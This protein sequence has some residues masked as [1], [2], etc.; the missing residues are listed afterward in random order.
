MLELPAEVPMFADRTDAGRR[1]ATA[2]ISYRGQP[3]VVFALPRGGVVLGVE[4]SRALEA[5]LDLIVVRKIGHPQSPEY[6]VGA[7]TEDGDIVL[8][9]DEAGLL[10]RDWITRTAE[11]ELREAHRRRAVFLRDGGRIP[12]NGKIAIIVDDGLATGLTMEAAIRQL[13]KQHPEKVIVAVPVAAAETVARLRPK[14]DDMVILYIPPMLG[15]VGAFYED[16]SQVSDEDVVALLKSV[17]RF[18]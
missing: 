14:V 11:A 10:D 13:R 1:L 18:G 17:A 9:P 6:A 8:N 3:V 16:F 12:A 15:A 4:V 7:I 5:P 2:L